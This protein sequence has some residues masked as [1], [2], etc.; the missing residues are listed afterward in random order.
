MERAVQR[1]SFLLDGCCSVLSNT[2]YT[3]THTHTRISSRLSI[4]QLKLSGQTTQKH[5]HT[6]IFRRTSL[7]IIILDN[8]PSKVHVFLLC[9]EN[10]QTFICI[11]Y[12]CAFCLYTYLN[13][14][15]T[16]RISPQVQC[17]INDFLYCLCWKCSVVHCLTIRKN[18]IKLEMALFFGFMCV[19]VCSAC[20]C[21][22]VCLFFIIFKFYILW[23]YSQS[24]RR[25]N[26]NEPLLQFFSW[27]ICVVLY[28]KHSWECDN[29]CDFVSSLSCSS[30]YVCF[31]IVWKNFVLEK[32]LKAFM[33]V[34][35]NWKSLVNFCDFMTLDYLKCHENWQIMNRQ[36]LE[37]SLY[38]R[39]N[40]NAVTL[41]SLW[42]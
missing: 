32:Q 12:T 20:I 16:D 40:L 19:Y 30:L 24:P 17:N 31:Y 28:E 7:R 37:L 13:K 23:D 10:F 11:F 8:F 41:Q 33:S 39:S 34:Y 6:H 2:H 38:D 15:L 3:R 18:Q 5:T 21:V 14:E 25:E 22:C 26:S 36:I 42:S 27:H 1:P 35:D 29:Y 4:P 9:T